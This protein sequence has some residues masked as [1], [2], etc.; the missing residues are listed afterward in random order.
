[1]ITKNPLVSICLPTFNRASDLTVCLANLTNLDY[2]NTEIVISDNHSTDKTPIICKQYIKK[3]KRIRYY[4]QKSN[5]GVAKNSL[6]V[7]KKAKGKYF[8]WASDD[9]LRNKTYLSEVILLLENNQKATTAI[10]STTLFNK[11]HSSRIPISFRSI[12]Q[13]M[14]SFYTFIVH[15]ECVSVL[16]YGVHRRT[17]KIIDACKRLNNEKR[18]FGIMGYDNSFGIFLVL[19]GDLIYVSK[20]LFFI[21]DNGLYLSVYEQLSQGAMSQQIVQRI[22]RYLLFPVMFLYDWYYGSMYIVRSSVPS[23][24]KPFLLIS[25]VGKFFLDIMLFFYSILKAGMIFLIGVIRKLFF[26]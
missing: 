9:D 6:F 24:T 21:R 14:E 17:Q 25:L 16:L 15:P 5:I 2:K 7:L 20:N 12:S 4:R 11:D 19:Q 8:F 1:M 18:L 3:D 26:R 23:Y 13:P 22:R 10:T